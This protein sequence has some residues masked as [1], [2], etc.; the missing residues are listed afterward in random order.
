MF[1]TTQAT[2]ETY[3]LSLHG[4]L[5]IWAERDI[6]GIS[7]NRAGLA[8]DVFDVMKPDEFSQDGLRDVAKGI[9]ETLAEKKDFELS[10]VLDRLHNDALIQLG[11]DLSD[12]LGR[13]GEAKALLAAALKTLQ[14]D[15]LRLEGNR[16]KTALS[17]A[18]RSGDEAREIEL[19]GEY[20]EH[21]KRR[22]G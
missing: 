7:L 15:R 1:F 8:R 16:L 13:R 4:A 11:V 12:D 10:D 18:R 3:P 21:L 6:L 17:E 14:N 22:S 9:C 5:P 19:L 2:P 20:Q